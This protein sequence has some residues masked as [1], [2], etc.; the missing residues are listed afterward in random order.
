[1][2]KTNSNL[3]DDGVRSLKEY[4]RRSRADAI[5]SLA[6]LRV[7]PNPGVVSGL[8]E[9]FWARCPQFGARWL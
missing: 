7:S 5:R 9:G 3:G 1:M 4:D 2:L 8:E 6:G